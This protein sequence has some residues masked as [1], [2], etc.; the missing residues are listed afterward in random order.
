MGREGENLVSEGLDATAGT[1]LEVDPVS[2]KPECGVGIGEKAGKL[3]R[4]GM[5]LGATAGTFLGVD[6]LFAKSSLR[7]GEGGGLEEIALSP[8]RLKLIPDRRF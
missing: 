1:F 6:P 2:T 4:E 3:E 7:S 8:G 5:R